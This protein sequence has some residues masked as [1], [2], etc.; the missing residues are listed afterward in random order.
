MLSKTN[1]IGKHVKDIHEHF[2]FLCELGRGAFGSVH[3]IQNKT[4]GDIYACKRMNKLSIS[5]PDMFYTEINL[6][7]SID[8]PNI[9][10]LYDI[11]MDKVFVYLI[12]EECLGGEL[13][14]QLIKR[15]HDQR[16]FSEKEAAR[17]FKE[18]IEAVNYLHA[19]KIIHRD[20][21]AENIMF[22]TYE[23]DSPLKI[24]DFGLSKVCIDNEEKGLKGELGS[25]LYKAPEVFDMRYSEKSDIWAC[26]V[27]LYMMLTGIPPFYSQ[28]R[29][30][31]KHNIIYRKYTFDIPEFKLISN[32]GKELIKSIFSEETKR[33]SAS[34]ILKSKWLI[35]NQNESN[36]ESL[37]IKWENISK[38]G[39]INIIKKSVYHFAAFHLSYD[40]TKFYIKIFKEYDLNSDGVLTIEETKK[41]VQA[42]IQKSSKK[43][44][45]DESIEELFDEIDMDGNILINFTEFLAAF[46]CYQHALRKEQILEC[47]NSYDKDSDGKITLSELFSV[48]KPEDE[49]ERL[50]LIKLFNKYDKN[51]DGNIDQKEFLLGIDNDI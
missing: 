21:K 35:G 2:I 51:K 24:I 46:Q 18:I 9:I 34:N 16:M 8:H 10:K 15:A 43:K 1:F 17:I 50:A 47:F 48:I 36:N 14:K 13:F 39:N 26:G 28:D 7:K 30:E 33:P 22:A 40:E 4:T 41:L 31:L 5:N 29:D 49:E 37:N 20:I 23:E 25:P 45:T 42:T 44:I 27:L 11:Y 12:L 19:F 38:Y 3:R 32:K 6:L